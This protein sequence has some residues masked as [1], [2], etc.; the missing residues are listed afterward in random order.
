MNAL[1]YRGPNDKSGDEVPDPTLVDDTDV[2]VRTDAATIGGRDLHVLKGNLPEVTTG[3]IFGHE[4]VGTVEEVGA[5]P[6]VESL[7]ALQSVASSRHHQR[8]PSRTDP[9]DA[10][11]LLSSSVADHQEWAWA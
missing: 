11:S 1:I 7:K 6:G 9:S 10:T 4:A 8:V 3:R 2:F 5:V